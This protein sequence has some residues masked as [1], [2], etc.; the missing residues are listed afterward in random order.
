MFRLPIIS[1]VPELYSNVIVRCG[2]SLGALSMSLSS[3][4]I[5]LCVK[6][7][8]EYYLFHHCIQSF[9]VCF[10]CDWKLL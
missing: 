3:L 6:V 2:S 1:G 5:Y 7:C 8:F 4:F 9:V 10:A